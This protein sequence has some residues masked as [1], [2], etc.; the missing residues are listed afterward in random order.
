MLDPGLELIVSAGTDSVV[1][2]LTVGLG[3]IWTELIGDAAV[4]PLPADAGADQGS[5]PRP[6]GGTAPDRGEGK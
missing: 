1:P 4:I 3:G 5:P 2:F 6:E